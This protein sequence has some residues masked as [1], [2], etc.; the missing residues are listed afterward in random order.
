M[1]GQPISEEELDTIMDLVIM[2]KART[3]PS[4]LLCNLANSF[5]LALTGNKKYAS[6]MGKAL[7]SSER[8]RLKEKF[9]KLE[10]LD[11]YPG[12]RKILELLSKVA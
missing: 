4:F 11:G 1:K 5:L 9:R 7:E 6:G 8:Q 10:A 12:K 3:A 2:P